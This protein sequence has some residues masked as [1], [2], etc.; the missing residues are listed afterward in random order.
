V[1][2]FDFPGNIEDYI[3][4]I[5][6]TGRAGAKG[7]AHTFMETAGKDGKYARAL[8]DIMVKAGQKLP[9]ELAQMAGVVPSTASPTRCGGT[10][11]LRALLLRGL[12]VTDRRPC[13]RVCVPQRVAPGDEFDVRAALAPAPGGGMLNPQ[14]M[15]QAMAIPSQMPAKDVCGDFKRGQCSRGAR[16]KYSHDVGG[17]GGSGGGGGF[18]GGGYGGGGYGGGGYGGGGFGAPPPAYGGGYGAPMG[19]GY[20]GGY[21]G[22]PAYGAP[23]GGAPPGGGGGFGDRGRGD[24][25]RFLD[26]SPPRRR[27]HSREG[28]RRDDY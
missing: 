9:R 23:P 17:G 15:Q 25:D 14:A 20:G 2:N 10:G 19:G 12:P 21:G 5:G 8:T 11:T 1:V 18:G 26:D 22:V 28:R 13:V 24:R 4:R 7:I 27:S 16:C 3:H 6:R